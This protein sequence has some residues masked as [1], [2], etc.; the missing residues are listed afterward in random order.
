[1]DQIRL[2][3]EA[4][5]IWMWCVV[6]CQPPLKGRIL[7]GLWKLSLI[8]KQPE[9]KAKGPGATQRGEAAQDGFVFPGEGELS[10][11]A[12]PGASGCQQP[13]HKPDLLLPGVLSCR[14]RSTKL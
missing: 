3:S 5:A 14:T 8:L 12:K 2:L 13:R 1:M 6:T 10:G 4:A 11:D 7:L 9:G